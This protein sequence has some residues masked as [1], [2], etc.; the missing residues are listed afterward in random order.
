MV[1]MGSHLQSEELREEGLV[2]SAG[3]KAGIRKAILED[4]NEIHPGEHVILLVILE[5]KHRIWIC[6]NFP[7]K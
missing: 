4:K 2:H 6:M 5:K 3:H 7:N 1:S